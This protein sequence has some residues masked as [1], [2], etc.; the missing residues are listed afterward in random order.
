MN[1]RRGHLDY[2]V[3]VAEEGQ[4]TRA[5]A[6]LHVAQPALSQA[7]AQLEG[8]LGLTLLQRHSRGVTLTPAGE[9]FLPKARAAVAA[10][11]EASVTAEWL[12]RAAQGSIEFGF[13]GHAPALDSPSVL[14]AF[15]SSH[16]DVSLR[17][18]ELPFPSSQTKLWLAEVDLAV[19]HRPPEDAGTWMHPLREEPRVVLASRRHHLAGRDELTVEEVIGETFVGMHPTVD[20]EWSGFWTLDDYRGSP[21]E[22]TGDQAKNAQEMIASIAA[23]GA[24]TTVP[25]SVAAMMLTDLSGIT[26][27]PLMCAS[28]AVITLSG[29]AD[30]NNEL[31]AELLDFAQGLKAVP[32]VHA[33]A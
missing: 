9:A 10:H 30:R 4:I 21:A 1:F 33:Q 6:R 22:V 15:R 24:I 29:H 23:S 18:R 2:F 26:A 5:A 3:A 7:M 13:V 16:P 8:E 19:C 11:R 31:V 28:P 17:F 20:K 12:A 27:I 32:G 25:G 14:A